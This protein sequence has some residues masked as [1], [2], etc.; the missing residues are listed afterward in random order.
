M[1]CVEKNLVSS[2]EHRKPHRK[3]SLITAGRGAEACERGSENF[4][5]NEL[6]S[7]IFKD[8]PIKTN[9]QTNQN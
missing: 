1:Y 8:K 7:D 4:G 2:E 5:V 6:E 3:R 9:A